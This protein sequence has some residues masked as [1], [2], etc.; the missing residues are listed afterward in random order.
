MT[1]SP[2]IAQPP[3]PYPPALTDGESPCLLQKIT[4]LKKHVSKDN[5]VRKKGR[6]LR[7]ILCVKGKYNGLGDIQNVSNE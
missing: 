2:L 7:D 1:T 5:I 3:V 6:I 4:A